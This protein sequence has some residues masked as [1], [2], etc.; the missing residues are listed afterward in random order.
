[1]LDIN[2]ICQPKKINNIFLV[3]TCF[4]LHKNIISQFS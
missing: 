1:M 4:F 2:L 3:L